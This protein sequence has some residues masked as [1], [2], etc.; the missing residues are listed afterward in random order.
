MVSPET[1]RKLSKEYIHNTPYIRDVILFGAGRAL[2]KDTGTLEGEV[3]PEY[4]KRVADYNL[5]G[6]EDNTITDR[7]KLPEEFL[8]IGETNIGVY[9][10]S[11]ALILF[12]GEGFNPEEHH[13]LLRNLRKAF[14]S[15]KSAN[16]RGY[17]AMAITEAYMQLPR[18]K[19]EKM[20]GV[21]KINPERLSQEISQL[22]IKQTNFKRKGIDY[23]DY[24]NRIENTTF[25]NI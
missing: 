24:L 3:Y 8:E 20:I 1:E 9:S 16:V 4:I 23:T 14:E 12:L 2:V 7:Y 17:S 5:Y 19:K 21:F 10:A 22:K 6:T 25:K 11:L 18:V 15:N 13:P